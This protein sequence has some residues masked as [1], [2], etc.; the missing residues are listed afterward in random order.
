[1]CPA[2]FPYA[3]DLGGVSEY[4]LWR[5]RQTLFKRLAATGR[6]VSRLPFVSHPLKDEVGTTY[7]EFRSLMDLYRHEHDDDPLLSR[8]AVAPAKARRKKQRVS[9]QEEEQDG[10]SDKEEE[11]HDV[12]EADDADIALEETARMSADEEE[13]EQAEQDRKATLRSRTRETKKRKKP[14]PAVTRKKTKVKTEITASQPPKQSVKSKSG[15]AKRGKATGI[16]AAQLLQDVAA[17]ANASASAPVVLTGM[18]SP[19]QGVRTASSSTQALI[20]SYFN[21]DLTIFSMASPTSSDT[22]AVPPMLILF[23]V[24]DKVSVAAFNAALLYLNELQ[25]THLMLI[26]KMK[27]TAEVNK[28]IALLTLST[29][30]KKLF[31]V[32]TR[33]HRNFLFDVTNN[34]RV[35]AHSVVPA[36][37]AKEFLKA[38]HLTA[39]QAK[40]IQLSDPQIRDLALPPGTMIKIQEPGET[41]DRR[42]V[43]L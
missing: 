23:C 26:A 15:V 14:T 10:D 1:M 29:K 35:R 9:D 27:A 7:E 25:L 20:N 31:R 28:Q 39:E 19:S 12:D 24:A 18:A 11:G 36:T 16:S 6:K 5:M 8:K 41:A 22:A 4:D 21:P 33:L 40:G 38:M 42:I 37:E 3:Y 43:R 2:P 32:V 34:V 17:A 30:E 13:D